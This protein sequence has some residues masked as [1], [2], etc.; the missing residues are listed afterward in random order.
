[1]SSGGKRQVPR[2]V[3]PPLLDPAAYDR[4]GDRLLD[5]L[6]A[7]DRR[8]VGHERVRPV[9]QPQLAVLPRHDVVD[10]PRPDGV[11]LRAALRELPG[12]H[13]LD[14]G[15]GDDRDGV[16]HPGPLPHRLAVVV[17]GVRGDPVDHRR[18][19]R[20]VLRD[21]GG[22]AGVGG[23][24][25][26]SDHAGDH[27]AVVGDVV[28]GHHGDARQIVRAAHREAQG[29]LAGGGDHVGVGAV[30]RAARRCRRRPRGRHGP[31]RRRR[32]AGSRPR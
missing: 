4:V 13:P 11:P 29:E 32:R 21:P 6:V 1:M 8:G 22:E 15:L 23:R 17:G 10:E 27:R 20:H 28:A 19:E 16:V 9:E 30:R 18:H 14:V 26:L 3:V 25:Q 2:G 31:G 7:A 24:G 5:G 12:E